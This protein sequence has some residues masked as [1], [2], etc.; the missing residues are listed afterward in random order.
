MGYKLLPP[1]T[2]RNNTS[3]IVRGTVGGIRFEERT[4]Q[5]KR[6]D[7]DIWALNYIAGLTR[8]GPSAGPALTFAAAAEAY[9]AARRPRPDDLKHILLLGRWFGEKPLS[10][11]VGADLITAAHALKPKVQ[12]VTK[13]Q[14]IV[15]P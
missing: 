4:G 7:A 3:Y 15:T 2:R 1:G 6:E 9:V 10:E 12:D 13:N 5:T 14:A 11:I 8:C